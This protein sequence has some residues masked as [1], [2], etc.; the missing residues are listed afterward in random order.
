M[1]K[2]RELMSSSGH[3]RLASPAEV[4]LASR[5]SGVLWLSGAVT[6]LLTLALP[7]TTIHAQWAI[8]ADRRLRGGLGRPDAVQGSVGALAGAP[9]ARLHHPGPRDRGRAHPRHREHRSGGPRLPVADR[10]L[11][12]VLLHAAP[13]RRL[14]VGLRGR[15]RAALRL[16]RPCPERQPRAP[17]RRRRAH[18]LPGRRR[19]HGRARAAGRRHPQ[20]ERAR[21]RPAPHDRGA[22]L[23]AAR[24]DRG[25]R[26]F[27][28]RRHLRARLARRRAPAGRRL[29]RHRPLPGRRPRHHPRPLEPGRARHRG[30]QRDSGRAPGQPARPPALRRGHR[31]RPHGRRAQLH[32]S[33]RPGAPRRRGVGRARRRGQ[34]SAR[35]RPRSRGA[36]TGLRRPHRHRRGQRRASR[37]GW[38]PRRRRTCSP[39]CPTTAPSASA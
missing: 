16:R 5:V 15:P 31:G 36:P 25:R 33:R 7:G 32:A 1:P 11:R 38:T 26:R 6:L 27:A 9:V 17:A 8:A 18:L 30:P 29:C 34:R 2:L 24:G 23:A 12:R 35:V 22:V 13:G 28:A 14:L 19:R 3:D 37:A 39:A 21:G 10:R 4:A 20:G